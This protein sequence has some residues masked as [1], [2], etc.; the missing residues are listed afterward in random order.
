MNLHESDIGLFW[1]FVETG[2]QDFNT[3]NNVRVSDYRVDVKLTPPP[4]LQIDSIIVQD[5][6][7]SGMYLYI[8]YFTRFHMFKTKFYTFNM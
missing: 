8:G 7:F 3:T 1:V 2:Y 4:D 5:V 6:T